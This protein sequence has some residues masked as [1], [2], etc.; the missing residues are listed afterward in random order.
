M[1]ANTTPIF[2]LTPRIESQIIENADGTTKKLLFAPGANGSRINTIAAC[3][4][5]TASVTL[6][7]FLSKDAGSTFSYLGSITIAAGYEGA[8]SS[9]IKA[10]DIAT[11]SAFPSG[12]SLYVGASVAVTSDKSVSLS[13]IGSDY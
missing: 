2:P 13:A 9:G 1:P 3:S 5:D 6:L 7:F 12:A 4:T 11:G 10:F 8:V